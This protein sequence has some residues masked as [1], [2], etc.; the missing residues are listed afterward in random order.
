MT[1]RPGTFTA[2]VRIS[3]H[4]A[5]LLPGK[6]PVYEA[7][8]YVWGSSENTTDIH[9]G[10]RQTLT[11][12]QNLAKALPYLR[13]KDKP[14]ILW[15][16]AIC[17]NQQNLRERGHQVMRMADI[18][19]R[20]DRVVVWLGLEEMDSGLG[21][22]IMERISSQIR[23]DWRTLELKPASRAT[24]QHWSDADKILP[25]SET[26]L[27]AISEALSRPWFE[28]LWVQQEIRLANAL[29]LF[30]CGSDMISW[31]SFRK[32]ILCLYV[33]KWSSKPLNPILQRLANNFQ[34][35]YNLS[36]DSSISG[37]VNIMLMT[38]RC[39]C[40]DPRDRIYAV[41]SLLDKSEKPVGLELDYEKTAGQVYQDVT[42]RYIAHKNKLNLLRFS[43]LKD[44]PSEMPTWVPD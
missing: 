37:F 3:I 5:P 22:E 31:H 20:A 7:L 8:S 4:K 34:L 42:L 29:A 26:E 2:D 28:R 9:V 23:V 15:I 19:S 33:K 17:V 30:M 24:E 41:L 27:L 18:Y 13:Y 38:N 10:Y 39:K 16:D 14:R 11:V 32:V 43:W 6:P 40:L 44:K 35:L 36:K 25:C 12:T 21:I 1:L